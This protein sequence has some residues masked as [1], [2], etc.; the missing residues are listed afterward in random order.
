MANVKISDLTAASGVVDANEFEIN[1][2]GTSKKVTGA[3]ISAKVR[4]D[5]VT[6]DISDSTVTA[7]ELNYVDGVT[8]SIQDQLD[9][10]IEETSATGSAVL[11][12]GTTAQR[13]GSPN[14][15]YIRFN[16]TDNTF[17]GYDGTEWGAIGGADF[18]SV[19]EDVLPDA[20]STRDLGSS[21]KY[22][23]EIYGDTVNASNYGDGT[24]TV[25]ASAVIQGTAKV[26]VAYDQTVP[27]IRSSQGVSSVTDNSAGN[28]TINYTNNMSE[29][30]N[31]ETAMSR[32]EDGTGVTYVTPTIVCD[33][34]TTS[35]SGYFI[36]Q[37]DTDFA[38]IS[39]VG[40]LA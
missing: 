33:D 10:K 3:Q 18:S 27:Q 29:P 8:S 28:F 11:P 34:P 6:A 15:G 30:K 17:E 1:E 24:D 12:A 7:T 39:I 40:E 19:A 37:G 36:Q 2:A 35:L 26:A 22:W 21:T 31:P 13:D 14:A 9:A 16:S 38:S 4:S 20:D 5:I 32:N 23:A 25:P